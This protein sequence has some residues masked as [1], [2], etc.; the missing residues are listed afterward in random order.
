MA[1]AQLSG[2]VVAITGGAGGI[3]LALARACGAAGMRVVIGDLDARTVGDVAGRLGENATGVVVDVR[4]EE[5]FSAFLDA[6][7]QAF[8]PLDVLVNNAGVLR[9]GPLAA[10]T[11]DDI[12]L[13]LDVNV[14]GVV[15]GTR[16][17]L[18]RFVPRGRGHIVNLASSASMVAAPN[19]AVYSASKHAVLGLTRAVRGELRGTAVRTTVVMPG[20]VRTEM[21]QDFASAFGVRTIEPEVVAG[22]IVSALR[23]GRP[24]VYVP[25]EVALQGRLFTLLPAR[26][27]DLVQRLARVD[28]VMR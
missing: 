23:T 5:S 6:A 11:A 20:V 22:A 3:G 27:S 15:T 4:D 19:G 25:R 13:Q 24:E 12:R 18:Q 16:L 7:E 2:S 28:R 1:N 10:A 8:G 21:T 17:A 26:A 9:M 14:R